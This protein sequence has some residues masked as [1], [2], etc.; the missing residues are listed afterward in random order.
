MNVT[1]FNYSIEP[2]ILEKG[3]LFKYEEELKKMF[4]RVRHK[5]GTLWLH[6]LEEDL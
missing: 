6:H 3:K 4:L 1:L 2:V 5:Q